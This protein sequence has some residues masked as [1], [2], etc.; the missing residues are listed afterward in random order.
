MDTIGATAQERQKGAS[1][2]SDDVADQARD[3]REGGEERPLPEM[4]RQLFGEPKLFGPVPRAY[5][6]VLAF[7]ET[8]SL[9][10]LLRQRLAR[11]CQ[12]ALPAEEAGAI[13][14]VMYGQRRPW[15]YGPGR[16]Y[17]YPFFFRFPGP[18]MIVVT[19]Q[20]V[21]VIRVGLGWI[22]A[23]MPLGMPVLTPPKEVLAQLPR[24][25]LIG[26]V[27]KQRWLAGWG[28]TTINGERILIAPRYLPDVE[29]ADAEV[30]DLPRR[31]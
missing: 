14:Y 21:W 23:G 16:L 1:M 17:F 8:Y 11:M 31:T 5:P 2:Q 7:V 9:W 3:E 6:W 25:T 30:A 22:N 19:E 10:K 13:R 20:H 24:E 4:A 18:R 12:L 26:P 27:D 28:R 29:A 15:C